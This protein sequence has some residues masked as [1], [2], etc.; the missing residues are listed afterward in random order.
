MWSL[1]FLAQLGADGRD[2]RIRRACENLFDFAT[3]EHGGLSADGRNS[4]L[5]HCLQGNLGAALIAFGYLGDE[6]LDRALD[7]LARSITGDGI[8]P[9]ADHLAPIRYLRSGTSGP[10]FLCSANN[11]LPC[12][13][14]AVKALLA[15]SATP[16]AQRTP[17][18]E[19]ALTAGANF[20][21]SRDPA[22]A[23]YPM[24]Y[25]DRPNSSW[26]KFGYPIAYVTDVLQTLELL[27]AL[28]YGHDQR[29]DRALELVLRKRDPQGR[30]RLEY[31]Y[32]GKTWVDVE[33]KGQPS[34]WVTLRAMRVLQRAGRLDA[35]RR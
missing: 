2:P 23:D 10:G 20:L 6:R 26:F 16:P 30:W 31:T 15:L 33:E 8:A 5:I 9:S 3:A 21:L 24:A 34:K 32:N 1:T 28:G 18:I 22:A 19:A 7:W 13:W 4:G 27:T 11:H 12:A 29:L 25:S 14:G 17:R 35:L